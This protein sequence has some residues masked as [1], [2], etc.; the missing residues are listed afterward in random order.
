MKVEVGQK[1]TD[2]FNLNLLWRVLKIHLKL[3]SSGRQ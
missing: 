3:R 2:D 1:T